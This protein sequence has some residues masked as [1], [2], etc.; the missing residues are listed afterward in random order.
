M[1]QLRCP[2]KVICKEMLLLALLAN[3]ACRGPGAVSNGKNSV[4]WTVYALLFSVVFNVAMH[5]ASSIKV[6]L[7]VTLNYLI[8]KGMFG[9]RLSPLATWVYN[10][11]VLF[12]NERYHGY[13]FGDMFPPLAFLVSVY[14]T[15]LSLPPSLTCQVV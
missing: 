2:P 7:L 10:L 15:L 6:A 5:G 9:I 11:S 8:G 3:T 4:A 13:R 1:L 12:L 14:A